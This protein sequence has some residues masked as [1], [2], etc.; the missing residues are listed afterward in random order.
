MFRNRSLEIP[1]WVESLSDT[2]AREARRELEHRQAF[3]V[4]GPA[5]S[6]EEALALQR[7]L[8]FMTKV[9]RR[10][11]KVLLPLRNLGMKGGHFTLPMVVRDSLSDSWHDFD[12][13][14]TMSKSR[15]ETDEVVLVVVRRTVPRG[16]A[17]KGLEDWPSSV[18][19]VMQDGLECAA[20]VCHYLEEEVRIS[21]QEGLAAAPWPGNDRVRAVREKL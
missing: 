6:D 5:I 3:F 11:D 9:F 1:P 21:F 13:L 14:S 10:Y 16:A 2:T 17:S 19:V 7:L 12:S 18:N 15:L 4:E 8:R 20:H